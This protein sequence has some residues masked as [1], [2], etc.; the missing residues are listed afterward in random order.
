MNK[1][2]TIFFVGTQGLPANYGG[3]ETF[4]EEVTTR[5]VKKDWNVYVTC[6]YFD[7]NQK[8]E[9]EYK[10][11]KLLHIL[12]PKNNLRTF[13]SDNIALLKCI[14]LAQKKDI[15]YLSGYCAGILLI[16]P[17]LLMKL[18]GIQFWLNP[19][20]LE[21]KRPR[22]NIM[23]RF[24]LRLAE[25]TLCQF[26]GKIICDAA[27]I[28]DFHIKKNYVNRNK[29]CVIEYGAQIVT[30][31]SP[32]EKEMALEYLKQFNCNYGEYFTYVGRFV[33]DNNMELMIRGMCDDS[34][35][36]KLLVFAR[37]DEK[38]KFYRKLKQIICDNNCIDKIILTGGVYD[39]NLLKALRLG[40]YA[41]L[42][43]H[44]VG[45]TNPALVE[46]MGLGRVVVGLDTVFNRE[47]LENGAI[48]FKKNVDSFIKG[49][50]ELEKL[51]DKEKSKI[52]NLNIDRVKNYYNWERITDEYINQFEA[53]K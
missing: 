7:R 33:P 9:S 52:S 4:V 1:N 15:I 26:A 16:Y 37:H 3:L 41:Y 12:S 21:W 31:S 20:G 42:H 34:I 2:K 35:K 6:E 14:K 25:F 43:G 22:W 5:L 30:K 45:G 27:A 48:Y 49:I 28:K 46:A 44:E 17:L 13:Y 10:G 36:R 39:Q 29:T 11:V 32:K 24:Y 8:L 38:D 53:S 51:D 47:V 40:D 19:D 18:R 50:N 23:V